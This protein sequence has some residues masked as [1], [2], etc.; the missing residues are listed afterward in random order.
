[1]QAADRLFDL[2]RER[3]LLTSAASVLG[4]DQETYLPP[5]GVAWRARQL[6]WLSARA[7]ELA[8]S[9]K[10]L[11]TLEQAELADD[12][13]DP[14]R[15]ANLREL[16]HQMDRATRLPVELVARASEASSLAKQAWAEARKK[17][18]FSI[19]R[20]HLEKMVGIAREKADHWGYAAEPYD[21]LVEGYERGADTAKLSSRL[22]P[23]R[24]PLRE[25]AARAVAKSA[26]NPVSLPEGPYPVAAQQQLNREIAESIG[27]DFDAGRIDTVTHPF[28]TGLGPR[29][30]RLTTR[31]R[32]NDFTD[33]LFGVLHES[34]HGL[35]DQ[36][37]PA[38]DFGLPTGSPVS[39]GIHESQSR[40]WENHVGGS[41]SF[42]NR[43]LPRAAELFPCLA[44]LG[45]DDFLAAVRRAEF[46]CI[47]V[48]ADEA[49]YDLHI[50]LRFDIERRI[51]R[52]DLAVD[53]VPAA[54]NDGF[55]ELFG[56][57]PPDDAR[58]C[59]Q[60]IHWA[61][62][63]FGYFATYSLGNI[64]AAQLCAA[65]RLDPAVS[66]GCD[67][68]DYLPLLEWMREH[69]HHHGSMLFPD[70]LVRQATGADPSH[71][72]YLT[73]LKRRYL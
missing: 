23:L 66:A 44:P 3:A 53:E 63:G 60:D 51:I 10:W 11:D 31:Y 21:A 20:D 40:L 9:K 67:T 22:D 25:L 7:H 24:D 49:T 41:R 14:Q 56:F 6:A 33:S 39:L 30:T 69:I 26:E 64:N 47:R 2:A 37:L 55:E 28:C 35:Y 29:D 38:S 42:W 72:D 13:A 8:T 65:A 19:F 58:G 27:F 12:G 52:G 34:G 36:G 15:A 5:S 16:R 68:A 54:W 32:E 50:L 62:G 45:L 59:L 46:S 18:D 70:D 71:A 17:S 43:W 48:E 1:M 61:M 73:H 57:V 4:W